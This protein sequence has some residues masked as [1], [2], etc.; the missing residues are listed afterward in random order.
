MVFALLSETST[1]TGSA[2]TRKE[3]TSLTEEWKDLLFTAGIEATFYMPEERRVLAALQR[4]WHGPD[5]KEFLLDRKE[6][7][8]V[9]WDQVKYTPT[10]V[11]PSST[12]TTKKT[13]K[14]SK[15]KKKATKRADKKK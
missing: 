13:A 8:E 3:V 4:G 14:S 1:T 9:E 11:A 12:G 6:V 10:P 7:V 15:A 2:W 5:V